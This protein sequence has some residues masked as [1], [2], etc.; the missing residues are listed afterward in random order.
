MKT[1]YKY[2]KTST[3]TNYNKRL[4][5]FSQALYWQSD[6]MNYLADKFTFYQFDALLIMVK[7]PLICWQRTDSYRLVGKP[8]RSSFVCVILLHYVT[9][10]PQISDLLSARHKYAPQYLKIKHVVGVVDG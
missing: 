1:L 10:L 6:G 5:W 3:K 8:D 9:V 4:N 2:T 7:E